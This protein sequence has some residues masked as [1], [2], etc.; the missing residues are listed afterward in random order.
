MRQAAGIANPM[1]GKGGKSAT[2]PVARTSTARRRGG[3]PVRAG[4]GRR[5]PA[6]SL[7]LT[8]RGIRV[9]GARLAFFFFAW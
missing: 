2:L 9:S 8:R 1:T 7:G 3:P 4:N 6:G 5:Q